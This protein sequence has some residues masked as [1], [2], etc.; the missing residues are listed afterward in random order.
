M[1]EVT[2][3][4]TALLQDNMRLQAENAKLK[5][6]LAAS[7]GHHHELMQKIEKMEES[8]VAIKAANERLTRENTELRALI[9]TL[10]KDVTDL[11]KTVS[12]LKQ[13]AFI[14]KVLREIALCFQGKCFRFVVD[15][16]KAAKE[17]RPYTRTFSDLQKRG[18]DAKEQQRFGDVETLIATAGFDED[19]SVERLCSTLKEGNIAGAHKITVQ[20]ADG[21]ERLPN[22]AE[23]T[24][25]VKA[26]GLDAT[27]QD[28]TLALIG[29][30]GEFNR[31]L[32]ETNFVNLV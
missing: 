25:W 18:K 11:K 28:E 14:A 21:K 32:N 26:S 8:E 17:K 6:E 31:L 24:Q 19:N 2:L 16:A 22:R 4:L 5:R 3:S 27:T 13:T 12:D 15:A 23:L 7:S 1:V 10:R 9:D 20:D 30:I 29:L